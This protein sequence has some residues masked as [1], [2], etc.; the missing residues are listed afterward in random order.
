VHS[1]VKKK[2][3]Q[4]D[5]KDNCT[6]DSMNGSVRRILFRPVNVRR[7]IEYEDKQNIHS[8][9]GELHGASE[10]SLKDTQQLRQ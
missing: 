3:L 7:T 1:T 4:T 2:V 8:P 9:A 5:R 6:N 10:C